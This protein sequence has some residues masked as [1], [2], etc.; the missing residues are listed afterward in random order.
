MLFRS[1]SLPVAESSTPELGES[2]ASNQG[3]NS[4]EDFCD[5]VDDG[6]DIFVSKRESDPKLEIQPK[7]ESPHRHV[8]HPC[9]YAEG[10]ECKDDEKVCPPVLP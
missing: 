10:E 6:N 8:Q 2:P 9:V 1:A 5:D 7:P 4:L 3:C